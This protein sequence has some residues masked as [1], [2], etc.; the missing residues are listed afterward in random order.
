MENSIPWVIY[1][2]ILLIV[3]FGMFVLGTR[4]RIKGRRVC[5]VDH[6][7]WF[8]WWVRCDRECV[9]QWRQKGDENWSD[10]GVIPGGSVKYSDN[11]E[12]RCVC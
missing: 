1:V 10:A 5:E 11:M 12:Y 9:L 3:G 7:W 6:H 2:V 4:A 8:G